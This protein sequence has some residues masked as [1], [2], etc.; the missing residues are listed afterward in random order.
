MSSIS[1]SAFEMK[2][3]SYLCLRCLSRTIPRAPIAISVVV[4][5]L[6]HSGSWLLHTV[7]TGERLSPTSSELYIFKLGWCTNSSWHSPRS[8]YVALGDLILYHNSKTEQFRHVSK[9]YVHPEWNSDSISSGWVSVVSHD[10]YKHLIVYF[11]SSFVK[12]CF[13]SFT[14]SHDIALLKLSSPVSITSYVKLASLPSFGEILPHNN[15][16][17]LTGYGST[18]SETLM[19]SCWMSCRHC[20]ACS[21]LLHLPT[22]GGGMPSRMR[23]VVLHSVDH[24]TCTSSG[25]WGSTVKTNMICA[26]GGSQSACNV[27]PQNWR[28]WKISPTNP[29]L[30]IS[31]WTKPQTSITTT[32]VQ[33]QFSHI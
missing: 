28:M 14:G 2:R 19:K 11:S 12:H 25:W 3:M 9:V 21:S 15:V 29:I 32:P 33:I 31:S 16:C 7:F 10:T 4:R 5:W 1:N 26:G 20:S 17:Y 23:Q 24:R 13:C 22:A 30:F 8:L 18:S 27:S 6:G